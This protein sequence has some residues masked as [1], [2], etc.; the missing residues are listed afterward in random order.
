MKRKPGDILRYVNNIR[1][2]PRRKAGEILC[3]NHVRHLAWTVNGHNGFRYF[4]CDG[5]PGHG[6]ELCPCG[7]RP[8]FGEHYANPGHV[9][10]QRERIA[11]GEPLTMWLHPEAAPPPG[12][13]RVGQELIAEC[14]TNIQRSEAN[15]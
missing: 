7:W 9:E 3:H 14:E 5:S 15:E 1:T 2:P 12:C 6:W 13:K 10:Y 11:A 8:D 4:V